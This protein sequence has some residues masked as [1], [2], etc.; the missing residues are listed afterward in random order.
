MK[1]GDK[2]KAKL[3]VDDL[4]YEIEA[5]V[6][7][8]EIEMVPTAIVIFK[9]YILLWILYFL[10]LYANKLHK[11]TFYVICI[12]WF[13]WMIDTDFVESEFCKQNFLSPVFV[14]SRINRNRLDQKIP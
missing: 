14:L 11:N 10:I 7:Y 3:A 12:L 5:E 13:F 4:S 1:I 6:L 8:D 2:I 9:I